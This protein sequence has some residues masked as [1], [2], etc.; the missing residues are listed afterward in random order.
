MISE[1]GAQQVMQKVLSGGN[2]TQAEREVKLMGTWRGYVA[3]PSLTKTFQSSDIQAV[4][5]QMY[6]TIL[7]NRAERNLVDSPE[8]LLSNVSPENHTEAVSI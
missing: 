8:K 5:S 7:S 3:P 6:A 1:H 2:A 4:L